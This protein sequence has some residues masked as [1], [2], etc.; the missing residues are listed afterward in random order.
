MK[1][2]LYGDFKR[3]LVVSLLLFIGLCSFSQVSEQ[4]NDSLYSSR[5]MQANLELYSQIDSL[6]LL[7]RE[8]KI[9]NT[10][11]AQQIDSL[12]D[13]V[14]QL[15]G[16]MVLS[17]TKIDTLL[18]QK[19]HTKQ[20]LLNLK[21][22]MLLAGTALEEKL[23][24]VREKDYLLN[25]CQIKLREA[26]SEASLNQA[27][28]EGKIDVN[29][30]KVEAR[31][32]EIAYMNE[33]IEE[34]E[35]I[36]AEK[37]EELSVFY[38]DKSTSLR[39]VDSLSRALNAKELELVKVSER[40]KII[41]SQ[42]NELVA[43]RTAAQNKKKKVRFVQGVALKN[44][45]T[46]DFQLAPQSSATT[47]TYVIT[48]KNSGNL[49]FDYI[50]GVSLSLYDLSK[51]EGKYTYDAGLFFG[52]G[53]TNLFKNFY[54]SPSFKAFDFFHFMIGLNIAEYQQ[55]QSGFNEGDVLPPGMGIPT[56]K[57]WKAN[58][59]FGMTIDFELLSNIPKKM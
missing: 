34:K 31:D 41:E 13:I 46:P 24:L 22:Q 35:R 52:F 15:Q 45:R 43:Q 40:L 9:R 3:G 11:L 5:L 38:H 26:K 57:E 53:G 25:E 42:Y 44:Y 56:V 12:K 37:T 27:K 30:T 36:I 55:L 47:A 59:F 21:Q 58:M 1:H 14:S 39:L 18:A 49:E 7:I 29:N 19:L 23:Q 17:N 51:P 54:V 48:N 8:T 4:Q 2:G 50:T 20:E 33:T 10:A 28:L 32:R 16:D 6:N